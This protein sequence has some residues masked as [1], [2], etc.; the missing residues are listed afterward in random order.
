[1]NVEIENLGGGANGKISKAKLW[2]SRYHNDLMNWIPITR[3]PF[4]EVL[5]LGLK[6]ILYQS[7]SPR[8]PS[9]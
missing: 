1:M 6:G 5:S 8:V 2:Y 9:N 3:C 7:L 4:T